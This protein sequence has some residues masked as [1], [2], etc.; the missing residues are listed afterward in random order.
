M[1]NIRLFRMEKFFQI[2]FLMKQKWE[3]RKF[4]F[5]QYLSALGLIRNRSQENPLLHNINI[6]NLW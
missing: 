5:W 6:H 2:Y 4:D 3:G 1:L